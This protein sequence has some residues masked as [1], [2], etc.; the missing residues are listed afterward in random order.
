[1]VL[2]KCPA[3]KNMVAGESEN[4]P[5]CGCNPRMR[6]VRSLIFWTLTIAVFAWILREFAVK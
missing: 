1:M 6:L 2:R 3:C 5:I 4:C